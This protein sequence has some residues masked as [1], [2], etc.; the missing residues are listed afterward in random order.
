MENMIDIHLKTKEDYQ[1]DYNEKIFSYK[2]SNY[3]LEE[4][5]GI[6]LK[7]KIKFNVIPEFY[8]SEE[9]KNGFVDMLRNN[10]GADVGEIIHLKQKDYLSN[11]L[12]LLLGIIFVVI[13]AL[14]K[15]K[16]LAQFMLILGWVLIG[17]TIVNFLHK[18]AEH[19]YNIERRKQIIKAK[20]VFKE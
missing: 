14:L 20:I 9:E 13:Y 17:E 3:I 11:I 2:L 12:I 1:N 4:T 10:Y 8:M 5:K 15:D 6:S 16:L 18:G 19:R 7:E